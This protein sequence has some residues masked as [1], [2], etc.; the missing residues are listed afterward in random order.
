MKKTQ[1]NPWDPGHA[2]GE[3]TNVKN[4]PYYGKSSSELFIYDSPN[5]KLLET[6]PKGTVVWLAVNPAMIKYGWS[7]CKYSGCIGTGIEAF[8]KLDDFQ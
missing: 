8:T 4:F 7:P 2:N 3:A 1:T 6:L 5:G